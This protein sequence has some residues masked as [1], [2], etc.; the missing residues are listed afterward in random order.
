MHAFVCFIYTHIYVYKRER[1]TDRQ[2]DTHTHA[3]ACAHINVCLYAC[4]YI[5]MMY[6]YMY[7][8]K[9][10][11]QIEQFMYDMSTSITE[12]IERN[13]NIASDKTAILSLFTCCLHIFC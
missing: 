2:T 3:H 8:F 1:Q 7:I 11:N 10:G 6:I 12:N 9:Q 4:M 13:L 5:Y